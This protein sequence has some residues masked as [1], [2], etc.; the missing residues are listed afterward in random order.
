MGMG[1]LGKRTFQEESCGYKSNRLGKGDV[2]GCCQPELG[3]GRDWAAAASQVTLIAAAM[4]LGMSNREP[5]HFTGM[6]VPGLRMPGSV[7]C[8]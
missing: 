6:Q 1:A 5:K 2:L 7:G 3:V 4:L 8:M